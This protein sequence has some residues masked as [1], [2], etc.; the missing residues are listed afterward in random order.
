M[1]LSELLPDTAIVVPFLSVTNH[2]LIIETLLLPPSKVHVN[3]EF[4]PS[5]A[6]RV[7]GVSSENLTKRTRKVMKKYNYFVNTV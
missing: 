1:K 2:S 4:S 7:V 3:S 5:S 6:F